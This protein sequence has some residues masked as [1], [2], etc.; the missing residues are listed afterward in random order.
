M[1]ELAAFLVHCILNR[2][3]ANLKSSSKNAKDSEE[4][5]ESMSVGAI[6]LLRSKNASSISHISNQHKELNVLVDF[7][8]VLGT[9]LCI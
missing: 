3:S 9:A 6:L 8:M 4:S 5:K 7:G 1:S 2:G